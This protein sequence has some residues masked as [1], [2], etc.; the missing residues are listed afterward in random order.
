MPEIKV[1]KRGGYKYGVGN[2]RVHYGY[3]ETIIAKQK[4][5]RM[6]VAAKLAE[7]VDGGQKAETKTAPKAQPAKAAAPKAAA[8]KKVSATRTYNRRDLKAKA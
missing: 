5:A 8:S 7:Y 4:D 3:G 6:L 1:T 2:A